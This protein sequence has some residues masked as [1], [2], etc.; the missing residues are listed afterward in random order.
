MD[1]ATTLSSNVNSMLLSK[2]FS[3]INFPTFIT[4]EFHLTLCT[5]CQLHVDAS[6]DWW[7]VESVDPSHSFIERRWCVPLIIIFCYKHCML[8]SDYLQKK[9]FVHLHRGRLC[10]GIKVPFCH[11]LQVPY[12]S[13]ITA[14]C[15]LHYLLPL[16][17]LDC[18]VQGGTASITAHKMRAFCLPNILSVCSFEKY[19]HMKLHCA[20]QHSLS[21][22]NFGLKRP[23]NELLYDA[24]QKI[25]HSKDGW[26][27]IL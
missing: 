7:P 4:P 6:C 24:A 25:K 10:P 27:Q 22:H 2:L 16:L 1:K 5:S 23:Q 15:L 18:I 13:L 19:V 20:A 3:L 26:N 8:S 14:W 21:S 12:Y 9:T 17:F 11:N